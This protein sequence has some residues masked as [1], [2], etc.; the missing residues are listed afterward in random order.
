MKY[1]LDMNDSN[2]ILL[3]SNDHPIVF[4][5]GVCYLCDSSIKFI[6]GKDSLGIFKFCTL[7][8]ASIHNLIPS[9]FD[10]KAKKSV[11]LLH[12]GIFYDRSDA[13]I[14]IMILLGGWL[15]WLGYLSLAF[16]KFIRNAVYNL[17][18]K[19]RYVWFGKSDTCLMPN[20]RFKSQF[21]K[22]EP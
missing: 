8:D 22:F 9:N 1:S 20:P 10:I 12:K 21:L 16:P 7:Q 2:D 4:Y 3:L 6:L 13:A 19:Y 17:I 14:H 18:S 5:D 15:S 11:I